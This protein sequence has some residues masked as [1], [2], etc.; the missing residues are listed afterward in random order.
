M[1]EGQPL[2]L[3]DTASE[4][5]EA[6]EIRHHVNG[7]GLVP[8]GFEKP[9]QPAIVLVREG[10]DDVIHLIGIQHCAQVGEAAQGWRPRRGALAAAHDQGIALVVPAAAGH[11]EAFAEGVT[12]EGHGGDGQDPEVDDDHA[13]VVVLAE[14]EGHHADEDEGAHGRGL[15]DAGHL[16]QARA[17]AARPVEIESAEGDAPHHENGEE[18]Q[19]IGLEK[20]NAVAGGRARHVEADVVGEE[21]A[22]GDE[23]QVAGQHHLLEEPRVRPQHATC[24]R[25]RAAT[26]RSTRSLNSARSKLS[27]RR[28]SALGSKRSVPDSRR[29]MAATRSSTVWRSKK[30][31][32]AGS[33]PPGGTTVSSA[34]PCPSAITGRPA[35]M[36]S[37]GVMPKSSR[38]GKIR[39]RQR[40]YS[41]AVS[42]S[43]RQPYSS[44]V[45]PAM[46]RS[47]ASSGPLPTMTKRHPRRLAASTTRSTR[48]YGVRAETTR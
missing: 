1:D 30:S 17:D 48:L 41:S 13:G 7:H 31:P 39:A 37:S 26:Y 14:E 34:P 20:G 47:R 45:G 5:G 2:E 29:R 18:H 24:S 4:R 25:H 8:D 21:P 6:A 38:V 23:Q 9:P 12:R 19:E 43:S 11:P 36:A 40:A 16:G 28:R 44:T 33:E 27:A 3:L 10:E 15:S 46:A 22:A 42:A 35:A 32:V